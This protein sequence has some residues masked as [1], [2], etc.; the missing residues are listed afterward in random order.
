MRSRPLRRRVTTVA[1]VDD[2]S[3]VN[4][5][6]GRN[7]RSGPGARLTIFNDVQADVVAAATAIGTLAR[8]CCGVND[9]FQV[10]IVTGGRI[11]HDVSSRFTSIA[12]PVQQPSNG[13]ALRTTD[14]NLV[15]GFGKPSRPQAPEISLDNDPIH[16]QTPV[17]DSNKADYTE[18]ESQGNRSEQIS[19]GNQET[20]AIL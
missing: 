20:E 10:A 17:P 15:G 19:W 4:D 6:S 5:A 7:N 13:L 14:L 9:E 2:A 11:D 18:I 8:C 16:L 12:G 1:E 3:A